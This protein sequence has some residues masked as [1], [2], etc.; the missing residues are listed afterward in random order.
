MPER[1]QKILAQAGYG[2]RRACEDFIAA[3]RVRVNGQI[4]TS[5]KKL[6]PPSIRSP[7]MECPSL[8]PNR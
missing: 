5:G 6:I 3:G 1:L 7:L 4:A 2:S 8:W